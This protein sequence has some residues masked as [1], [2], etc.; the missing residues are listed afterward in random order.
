MAD[1]IRVFARFRPLVGRDLRL[2]SSARAAVFDVAGNTVTLRYKDNGSKPKSNREGP[3]FT[4]D[5]VFDAATTQEQLHESVGR[6]GVQH[7]LEGYNS[8]ILTY[9]QTGSGKTFSMYGDESTCWR[10]WDNDTLPRD[11]GLVPRVTACLLDQVGELSAKNTE[12]EYAITCSFLEIYNEKI[13]DLFDPSTKKKI[14][15]RDTKNEGVWVHGLTQ[16]TVTTKQ[17]VADLLRLGF[18]LRSV[19]MT[20]MNERSSRSHCIFILNLHQNYPDG[21]SKVSKLNLV[22]LA[23]SERVDRSGVEGVAMKEAQNINKSLS[24]LGLCINALA[25]QGRH[26]IPYRDSSLT[27]LLKESLGGNAKTFLLIAL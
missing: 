20:L 18:G 14:R 5:S 7:L 10:D 16:E 1:N 2:S 21:S 13:K 19:G 3:S 25:E 9:G 15:V 27:H 24:C 23:G 12:I 4:F 17:D 22:D 6:V 11:H 8:T 26:H